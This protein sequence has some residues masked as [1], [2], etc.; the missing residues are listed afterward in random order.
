MCE[1]A[2]AAQAEAAATVATTAAAELVRGDCISTW[3]P[4][5]QLHHSQ[6]GK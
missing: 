4:T 6:G 2:V 3:K 5:N 1:G